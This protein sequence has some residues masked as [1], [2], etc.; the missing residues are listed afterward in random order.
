M[1]KRQQ[2]ITDASSAVRKS[3]AYQCDVGTA[4]AQWLR[5][6]STNRKVAVSIPDG[7]TGIFH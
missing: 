3:V 1:R 6:C 7:V 4:V 5:C 2:L